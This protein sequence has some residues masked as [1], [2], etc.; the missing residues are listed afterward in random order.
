MSGRA[1]IVFTTYVTYRP[2]IIKAISP[3]TVSTMVIL[4]KV[5][6]LS[7]STSTINNK[8]QTPWFVAFKL[9]NEQIFLTH[10]AIQNKI[11]Q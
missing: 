1:I 7:L 11:R 4:E 9:K 10:L 8:F 2:S 5:F 3:R 6:T